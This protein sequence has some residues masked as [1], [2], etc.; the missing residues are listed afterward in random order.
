MTKRDMNIF[1][2]SREYP[3]FTVGGTSTVARSLAEGISSI[4]HKRV[5][6]ITNTTNHKNSYEVHNNLHIYRVANEEIYT[7]H[8]ILSDTTLRSHHRIL[9]GAEYLVSKIGKPD[10][11]LLPDL[12]CLPEAK[13]IAKIYNCPIVNILLQD[14]RKMIPYDR[15]EVHRVSNSIAANYQ[16]LLDLEEKSLKISDYNVFISHSISH[17]INESYKLNQN[18][19]RV[20]YLGV[21]EEEMAPLPT[22]LYWENRGKL[23]SENEILI[24]SCGRLV[25]VK[26][27]DYLIKAMAKLKG[28]VSN[29]QLAIIGVGPELPYLKGLVENLKL[30]DSVTFLGDISRKAALNY[31]KVADIA[32]VPS[33]WES[34]CY[35]AAEFMAAGKPIVCTAVDSLNE[36]IRDE[37]DG[38]K[39]PVYENDGKR[40]LESEDIFQALLRFI[41]NP[42]LAKE[43]GENARERAFSH[44]SNTKFVEGIMDVCNGLLVKQ[45]I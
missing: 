34:F 10:I 6:V 21:Y 41:K 33:I 2:L 43:M 25:P 5:G 16:N 22:K 1:I 38:I 42:E 28:K 9:K 45:N 15:N 31:F 3:P 13:L 14:F 44:F 7:S 12:F 11:I 32:V 4:S 27:M 39:I 29:V 37:L 17:S 40:F 24:V 20:V 26:G 19:Q 18:N 35:V 8:S 30:K 36:L 23:A